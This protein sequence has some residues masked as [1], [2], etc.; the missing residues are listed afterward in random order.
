MTKKLMIVI[1][2][3]EQAN[4]TT[5]VIN[6]GLNIYELLGVAEYLKRQAQNVVRES[7]DTA[8]TTG[9]QDEITEMMKKICEEEKQDASQ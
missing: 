6:R 2:Q 5:A 9:G 7:A 1:T 4:T 8:D 3:D